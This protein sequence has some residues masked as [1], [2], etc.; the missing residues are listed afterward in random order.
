MLFIINSHDVFYTDLQ[1]T[2]VVYLA[3]DGQKDLE[4]KHVG[5]Y[6]L[7]TTAQD[8]HS[9][10]DQSWEAVACSPLPI[11]KPS[12]EAYQL[13]HRIPIQQIRIF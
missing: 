12:G 2:A 11:W 8:V 10:D 13:W 7:V 3:D 4:W 1:G 9:Q 6:L 5:T